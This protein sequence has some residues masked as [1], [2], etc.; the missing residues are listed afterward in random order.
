MS[1]CGKAR[2][3][4]IALLGDL[5]D[6][7]LLQLDKLSAWR[8]YSSQEQ[9]FD[10]RSE[11][12]DIYFLVQG[13]VRIVNY[14]LSGQQVTFDERTAGDH[15]GELAAIDGKPRSAS[16]VALE[17]CL[18]ATLSREHFNTLEEKYTKLAIKLTRAM[19]T[20]IRSSTERIMDLSTLAANNRVQAEILRQ[21]EECSSDQISAVLKPIPKH[22]D[23]ASR[24][25]TTRE[26]VAR[27][28]NDLAR[29]NIVVRQKGALSIID[30]PRLKDRVE[31]VRGDL[32]EE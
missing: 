24:V 31:R 5:P 21:A 3:S 13:R 16:A 14:S 27:V 17:D 22:R 20:I 23:I 10:R 29:D 4:C 7:E 1:D 11:T 26:T 15:F 19:A 18:I 9:L 32:P 12:T 8:T 28:L 30:M 25:S 6:E 2:L